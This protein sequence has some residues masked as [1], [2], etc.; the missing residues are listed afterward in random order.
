MSAPPFRRALH[1]FAQLLR[2]LGC[3]GAR[4]G[5]EG[6]GEIMLS[7]DE[8]RYKAQLNAL[9]WLSVDF[10]NNLISV[11]TDLKAKAAISPGGQP[12]NA[13]N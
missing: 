7:E 6:E 9:R 10:D 11:L 13:Y 4:A 2:V 8:I 3:G 5:E 12:M 1:R